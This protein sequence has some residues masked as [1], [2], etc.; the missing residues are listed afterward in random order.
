MT[1]HVRLTEQSDVPD[2][3]AMVEEF[4]QRLQQFEP[5]M[6]NRAEGSAQMSAFWFQTLIGK[7]E[8][9]CLTAMEA[10]SIVGFLIATETAAP[11][12]FN[13]GSRVGFIDDFCVVAPERWDDVGNA[14]LEAARV[15][16]RRRGIV[17]ILVVTAQKDAAKNNF[18]AANGL[19]HAS[20]WWTAPA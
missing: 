14:L 12:V 10:N 5:V 18:L 9:V 3:V 20:S 2:C 6:W 15:E 11:P 4:R 7:P 19:S 17:Q 1:I 8:C 16:L 13:P